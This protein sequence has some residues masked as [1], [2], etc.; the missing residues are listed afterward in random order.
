MIDI[1]SMGELP[2]RVMMMERMPEQNTTGLILLTGATG[3][4]GAQIARLLLRDTDH[5]LAVLVRGQNEEDARRRLERLW[6][7]WPET[8]GAVAS[9]RVRVLAG[10]LGRPNLGLDPS[11]YEE[12]KRTLT[13][14]VHAAAELKLDGELEELRRINVGGTA[15][16]L[17]LARAV[18]ADHGLERYAH[19]S[20][21]Y[22]AGGRTGEVAEGELTDRYGFSNAYEQTKYEGELK[23]RE[24]MRELPVSVFRP[25]MV[26]GHSQTG[27]IR[28]FNTVYV[29]LR[30]YLSGRLRLIP[31]RPELGLNLVPVDYVAG[32]IA[33]LAFDPRATG[34][35]FHL[36]VDP[37]HL[38][39]ARWLLQ[40]ARSWAAEEL[41]QAPPAARFIPMQAL[42][43]LPGAAKVAVP[44]FL[45]SYFSEDRR[46]RRDNVE[47]L[48]GSYAPDWQAI[49]P[50]LF[51]YAVQKGFLHRSGRTVHEQVLYRLQSRR[52]PVRVHDLAA[53]GS[54]RPRGGAELARE[55]AA[56]AGAL[57]SLGVRPGDRVALV[58]LNSSRYLALDTAVGLTGAVSVPLYY[59]SPPAEIE[60]ILQASGA[61]LLLVGAPD[62]LA[63]VGEMRTEVPIASFL[64][65]PLPPG[66]AG[67]VIP[68]EEFLALGREAGEAKAAAV[69]R[70]RRIA[71]QAPV[72][73]DDPATLR[74]TSGT[75]GT[76]RAAAFRHGQ[77][78]WM[79]E[80]L[81]S[82]L[83]WRARIRP[84][85]YLSFLP[86]NHVV[87]GILGAYAPYSIP[88]PVDVW[89]LENFHALP[90]ALP[91]VR[92]TVFFSVP[93]FYEKIWERFAEKGPGRLYLA[94]PQGGLRRALRPLL[95]RA[96]LHRAGLDRCAQLMVGSAPCSDRLLADF[97]ELGVEIHNAYGLTEAPLVTLNRHGANRL[98][99]AGR[100][101]PDTE[102][103]LAPDGEVLV[104]GP[105][106]GGGDGPSSAMLADGWFA[107]G[108]LGEITPEGSLI[109][110]GRKKEILVTS[111]GKNI[112]PAK[113][114]ALLREIPGLAEVML[115]G[116]GRPALCALLWLKGGSATPYALEAVDQA[117]RRLNAGL[118]H[119]EQVKRWAVLAES[120]SIESGELTGNLKLRRQVV[121]TRRAGVVNMLYDGTSGR[122]AGDG[123]GTDDGFEPA[124]GAAPEVLHVGASR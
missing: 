23:V 81:A 53:D 5:R 101:L 42:A 54:E 84:A 93:R 1:E 27:E 14:I 85:R 37:D 35:T 117:V 89:F 108:D 38:P 20:T 88:A 28:A 32:A 109:I 9:G 99:T 90:Y 25:G 82:L 100:P 34:L 18:H 112:H 44:S 7:D 29:P 79:A 106:V 119:P 48:L 11:T 51:D 46:F 76:P 87:E 47:R 45:L 86:M 57:R 66:L 68:W 115:L 98:G 59:T 24:A 102:V 77:V 55:I 91:R 26:V 33:R 30:L 61:R 12:L 63:R 83:P 39:Q 72:G 15:R 95:R 110:R 52:L 49:L 120:P 2:W 121:L 123:C 124:A 60:G 116:E 19:V 10:D 104:R 21:A 94:L 80:T 41:G 36:T 31:A 105:Q 78:L 73:F 70:A 71:L 65:G 17:E 22:V 96:L 58:G 114:E 3:F 97:H 43:R 4:L 13:H 62:V 40:A 92:P 56:A 16:L 74:F 118:S 8:K 50:R 111:Y 6:S 107:T 75:T 64:L 69:G 67:R 113:I 103:R 122:P